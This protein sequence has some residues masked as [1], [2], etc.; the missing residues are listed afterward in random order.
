MSRFRRLISLPSFPFIFAIFVP[1]NLLSVNLSMFAPVEILRSVVVFVFATAV[2]LVLLTGIIRNRETAAVVLFLV[3]IGIWTY[4]F[5]SKFLA[6]WTIFSL[7]ALICIVKWPLRRPGVI[8]LNMLTVGV[9]LIPLIVIA[10]KLLPEK[11]PPRGQFSDGVFGFS[12]KKQTESLPSIVHIVLDGYSSNQA[13]AKIYKFDNGRFAQSLRELGFVV[14]PNIDTP[15]NQTLLTM[16]SIFHGDYLDLS[17]PPFSVNDRT[18]ISNSVGRF[19]TENLVHQQLRK[20]GYTLGHTPIG[21]GPLVFPEYNVTSVS[22]NMMLQMNLF[23]MHLFASTWLKQMLPFSQLAALGYDTLV[24]Q[25]FTDR[26]YRRLQ[27][28]FHIYQ[29]VLAPHPPFSMDRSGESGWS[30]NLAFDSISD[31]DHSTYG[32]PDLQAKYRSGYVEKLIYTNA[33]ILEQMRDLLS[34]VKGPK[35]VIIHGDH[36]GGSLLLQEDAGGTCIAERMQTFAA[37]YSDV[38]AIRSAFSTTLAEALNRMNLYRILFG[39][40]F[41]MKLKPLPTRSYFATWG[42]LG[43]FLAVDPA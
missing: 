12:D 8:V 21:Y 36:G 1:L 22:E 25:A 17:K 33:A 32:K 24:R 14:F 11:P 13:L 41:E 31:G 29:H 9:L 40:I 6:G 39:T 4:P 18:E 2:L 23:E 30:D 26:F 38:D 19:I 16:S 5:G 3:L 43:A 27:E 10:P 15:Y 28:P 20:A 35:V 34:N 42:N 7:G 37:V